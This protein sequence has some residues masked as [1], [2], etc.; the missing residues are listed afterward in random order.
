MSLGANRRQK[1]LRLL[2]TVHL[3]LWTGEAGLEQGG[4][5][6]ARE[7]GGRAQTSFTHSRSFLT[8][9]GDPCFK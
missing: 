2:P 1:E 3:L 5:T 6:G 4:E 9:V 7:A 8:G